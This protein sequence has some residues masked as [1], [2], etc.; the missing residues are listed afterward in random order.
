MW[1]IFFIC[2]FSCFS[3]YTF[4][5]DIHIT[6]WFLCKVIKGTEKFYIKKLI[7]KNK[8]LISWFVILLLLLLKQAFLFD[9]VI[10]NEDLEIKYIFL[11]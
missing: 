11:F 10:F 7:L 2:K 5:V 4:S 3:Y 6:P 9:N 1:F 8:W